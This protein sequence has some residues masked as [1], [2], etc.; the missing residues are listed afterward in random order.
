MCRDQEGMYQGPKGTYHIKLL[1]LNSFSE[2]RGVSW[3]ISPDDP[4]KNKSTVRELG[5]LQRQVD[6]QGKVKF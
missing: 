3:Q 6:F 5:A 2:R 1:L 4:F